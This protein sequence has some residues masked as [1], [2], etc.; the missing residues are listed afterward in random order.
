M[1]V[2]TELHR[3]VLL[4]EALEALAIVPGGLCMDLTFGRGGHAAAI[5]D[6][7]GPAGRLVVL[8]QDPDAIAAAQERFGN[9]AR[10]TIRHGTFA[11]AAAVAAELGIT[12]QVNGILMD[13]GVSSTQLDDPRR[14]FSF[15]RDGPLDMRMNTGAG[16]S[17]ADWLAHAPE[18]GIAQ[19]LREY[20]EERF[21]R[22]VARAIVAERQQQPIRTTAHLRSVVARAIPSREPGK[23]PATRT[24]QAIR[25]HINHELEAL[26]Q[27]LD[28]VIDLLGV[29][30]RLAV[31]SFHS[32]EDRMVK[33][34]IRHQA[35]GDEFPRGMPIPDAARRPRLRAIGKAIHPGAAEIGRNPRARSAVMRVAEKLQ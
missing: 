13:L 29:G 4:S 28:Q 14:G 17:A 7:L 21:S 18:T 35:R 31:I 25:I 9:D 19:V 33:R 11:G 20:G 3:P 6:R 5:L 12:G 26:R 15:M 16:E 10:V 34:F 32:L 8:D 1:A 23:D 24:F 30:G 2:E 27:C 22:R